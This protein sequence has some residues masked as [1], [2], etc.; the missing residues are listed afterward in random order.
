[1]NKEM[2][3]NDKKRLS[4][5]EAETETAT[6]PYVHAVPE[7]ESDSSEGEKAPALFC[8]Y[9]GARLI[10]QMDVC[11]NCGV[12]EGEYRETRMNY[13][14]ASPQ[15]IPEA[16]VSPQYMSENDSFPEAKN[17][18]KPNNWIINKILKIFMGKDN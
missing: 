1:M 9:C 6:Y 13:L 11:P 3:D 18:T 8:P 17:E 4:L 10:P 16:Y 2:N 5:L 15:Y 12:K 14:Y 7:I